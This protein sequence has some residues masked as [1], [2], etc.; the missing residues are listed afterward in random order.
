MFLYILF[1]YI[2]TCYFLI[3]QHIIYFIK[4]ILKTKAENIVYVQI[5][6]CERQPDGECRNECV[7]NNQ[8]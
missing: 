6:T 8:M 1:Y 4:Y 7:T 3:I 2:Y 5:D